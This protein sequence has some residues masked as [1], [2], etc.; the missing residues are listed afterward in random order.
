MAKYLPNVSKAL[1]MNPSTVKWETGTEQ[2]LWALSGSRAY[3]AMK[4]PAVPVR[5]HQRPVGPSLNL[6]HFP[7]APA[8]QHSHRKRAQDGRRESPCS[9]C[10][11]VPLTSTTPGASGASPSSYLVSPHLS[12][13]EDSS[14]KLYIKEN[15]LLPMFSN[16]SWFRHTQRPIPPTIQHSLSLLQNSAA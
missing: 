6:V 3:P 1:G 2:K 14:S 7:W 5:A 8:Y 4:T 12:Y 16:C 11:V 9:Y 10:R 13:G 15:Y